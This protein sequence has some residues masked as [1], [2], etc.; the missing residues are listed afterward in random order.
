MLSSKG[1]QNFSL[2]QYAEALIK[3]EKRK[4]CTNLAESLNKSHDSVI[5]GFNKELESNNT[6]ESLK[7]I[8]LNHLNKESTNLIIDDSLITK[9][10]SEKIEGVELSFDG[11]EGRPNPGLRIVTALLTDEEIKIPIDAVP[12]VSKQLAQSSYK[13]KVSIAI[14]ITKDVSKFILIHRFLA[15]AHFSTKEMLIFLNN[16]GIKF[17]MKITRRRI[18]EIENQKG[19]LQNILRLRKNQR[20]YA[21]IGV[22]DGKQYYF[23]VIKIIK[24]TIIYFISNDYIEPSEIAKLYKIRWK[25]ELFH[26]TAKQ[27][28]GLGDCQMRSIEK[29]RQHALYV[30]HAYAYASIKTKLLQLESIEAYIKTVRNAKPIASKYLNARSKQDLSCYA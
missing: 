8:A 2:P 16:E 26:R 5:R 25:I 28:F 20:F 15:D 7:N 30:M 10:Y 4:V 3:C 17:L 18:V 27:T 24:G 29:Q 1:Y 11:S 13:S 23:Y 6:K 22:L 12:Y 9:I 14:Q 19:Q 21:S